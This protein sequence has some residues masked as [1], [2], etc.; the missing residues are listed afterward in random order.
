MIRPADRHKL[1]YFVT[2]HLHMTNFSKTQFDDFR[3]R[4][5]NRQGKLRDEIREELLRSDEEHYIDLAGSVHDAG[6]ESVADLLADLNIAIIDRQV[7]EI[8]QI[9]AALM[10]MADG[11]YGVCVECGNTPFEGL[12]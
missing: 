3:K 8:R 4:L 5:N 10:R 2:E 7:N 6:E 12:S 1:D 11:T 9:E